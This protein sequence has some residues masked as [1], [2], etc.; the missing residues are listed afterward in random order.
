MRVCQFRH[1]RTG[2]DYTLPI[3]FIQLARPARF[4][5][6]TKWFE[7]TYSIQLS[8]GRVE[9]MILQ[10]ALFFNT[11]IYEQHRQDEQVD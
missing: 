5:L 4:E 11:Y 9:I 3:D 8:Y 6:A 10:N 1:A 2:V 7:A